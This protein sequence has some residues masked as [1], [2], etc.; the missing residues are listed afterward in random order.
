MVLI[1]KDVGGKF[2]GG[3]PYSHV[4]FPPGIIKLC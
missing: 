1:G 3:C 2:K 4:T